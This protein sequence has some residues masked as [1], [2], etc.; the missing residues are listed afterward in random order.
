M[1]REKEL[2]IEGFDCGNSPLEYPRELVEGR[3]M[4]MTT[5]NGTRA[6]EKVLLEQR[7]Y[8]YQLF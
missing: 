6:I 5:S 8:I 2:K 3:N 4:Y 1:E 7:K